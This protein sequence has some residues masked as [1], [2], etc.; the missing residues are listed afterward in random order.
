MATNSQSSVE[1]GSDEVKDYIC[2][3]CEDHNNVE[4]SADFYCKQ[5]DRFYCGNCLELHG[6]VFA[7]H[8][9]FE[10]FYLYEEWPVSKKLVEF[11]QTCD[12]HKDHKIDKFCNL[13]RQLCCPQCVSDYHM[14]CYHS[15]CSKV[16]PISELTDPQ[17]K[18][19][20]KLSARL[21]TVLEG[22]IC[23][24]SSHEA[25]IKSLQETCKEHGAFMMEQ[26]RFKINNTVDEYGN[27][28]VEFM[29][30]QMRGNINATSDENEQYI[31][32]E[33]RSCVL[34]I[35]NE[36]DNSTVK[37][38]KEIKDEVIS[39]T[40]SITSSIDK[41][42]VLQNALTQLLETI[43]KIGNNKEILLIAS[44]KCEPKI[45]HS[46]SVLGKSDQ[47]F[48]VQGI[49]REHNMRM[50]MDSR[51][52]A[53]A[54]ICVL[55][56]GQVLC[57]D[58]HNKKVKLLD[59]QYR[60]VSHCGVNACLEDMCQITP[61]KVAVIVDD[62]GNTQE[63]QFITVIQSQLVLGRKF[64]LGHQCTGIAHHQ[65][66]LFIASG[67][68]LYK[69]SLSGRM[70]R[71]LYSDDTGGATVYRC[72][73]SPTGDKLYI[74]SYYDDRL[75]T[76][77]RDGKDLDSELAYYPKYV[78]EVEG[79]TDIHVTPAGQ[80][81]VCSYLSHTIL[82]V[83]WTRSIDPA[84]ATLV[85]WKKGMVDPYSVCYNNTTSS[86]IVGMCNGNVMVF[87]VK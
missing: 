39:I 77:V 13:H 44:I 25:S 63:V 45:Q 3:A 54:A 86:I 16:T 8:T 24:Q 1:N 22:I 48:T 15:Q 27:S 64:K 70:F 37:E 62:G 68:T 21:E 36:F 34:S 79:P 61:S 14:L 19:L 87:R 11:M 28:S 38:L 30:K 50:P 85:T 32:D 80:V 59:Q 12:E 5:C 40:D 55:P 52:P 72:A 7:K 65:G 74:T 58:Y 2:N 4:T 84:L 20:Q 35:L 56:D 71:E 6:K 76:L 66:D 81:L 83:D 47:V 29:I 73:V 23:L 67:T 33:M 57:L 60:V 82:Q 42:I 49:G 9:V 10:R 75:I 43:Y 18:D 51:V 69:Y 31:K 46:M 26:M 17:P 78:R 41:C 53:I